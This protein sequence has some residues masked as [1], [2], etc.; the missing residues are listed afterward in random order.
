VLRLEG[1][2]LLLEPRVLLP[3]ALELPG[4]R[5]GAGRHEHPDCDHP[6]QRSP[7]QLPIFTIASNAAFSSGMTLKRDCRTSGMSRKV[8][9]AFTCAKVTDRFSFFTGARST[10]TQSPA[11]AVGSG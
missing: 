10:T 9:S 1:A 11:L 3:Q 7:H 6:G 4:V 5:D 8:R 2:H